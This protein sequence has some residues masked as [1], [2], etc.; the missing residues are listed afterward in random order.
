[1][2]SEQSCSA[3]LVAAGPVQNALNE[4]LLE[5]VDGLIKLDSTLH[6]L[7]DKGLQLVFQGRTLRTRFIYGRKVQPNLL[8]FVAC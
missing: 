1:V 3:R 4:F 5:F 8:E 6:H 2:N 7:P